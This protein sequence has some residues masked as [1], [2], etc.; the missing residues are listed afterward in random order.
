MVTFAVSRTV[1]EK[2]DMKQFNDLDLDQGHR[3][4]YHLK[5]V[6][7]LRI[8]NFSFSGRTVYNFR[9]I[10]RG[11]DNIGWN[12]LQISF[13]VIERGTNRKL[14]YE[15]L[16]LMVVYSNFRRVTH[17]FKIQAVLM[18]KTNNRPLLMKN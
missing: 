9:D 4:S 12:D 10:G 13:K 8:S 3:Q 2:F 15:L 14:V 7:W 17:R 6:W 16:L 11:N 5:A 18:L 1:Y